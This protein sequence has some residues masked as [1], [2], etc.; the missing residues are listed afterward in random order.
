MNFGVLMESWVGDSK[1]N[2]VVR[3]SSWEKLNSFSWVCTNPVS[4]SFASCMKN[5]DKIRA[6]FIWNSF[7]CV[8][9]YISL[10]VRFLC[11]LYEN[12]NKREFHMKL[13]FEWTTYISLFIIRR[14]LVT[15]QLGGQLK[16]HY[17]PR[18][19]VF[20]VIWFQVE[21]DSSPADSSSSKVFVGTQISIE[22]TRTP[23]KHTYIC[24]TPLVTY[25]H[26]RW[27][28]AAY[29]F[30]VILGSTHITERIQTSS[31][32][33]EPNATFT[34]TRIHTSSPHTM[35]YQIS[36]GQTSAQHQHHHST[37]IHTPQSTN[38]L[39]MFN[40]GFV[41]YWL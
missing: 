34:A 18:R 3:A 17:F 39:T 9:T 1:G 22:K 2:E 15:S 32:V 35:C 28:R 27:K 16:W 38:Y 4:M 21:S 41:K 14:L 29:V 23:W 12:E 37:T 7:F 11:L 6:Y 30:I 36:W 8:T 13:F 24:R 25:V 40:K 19:Y 10:F 26:L 5:N 20:V 33:H 31:R